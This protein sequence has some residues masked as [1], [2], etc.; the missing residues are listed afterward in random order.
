LEAVRDITEEVQVTMEEVEDL[1]VVQGIT[2][3]A[4]IEVKNSHFH[5]FCFQ[6]F[7]FPLGRGW[8]RRHGYGG[9]F[10]GGPGYGFGGPG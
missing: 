8:R 6:V 5:G 7:T 2:V 9:G 10:G 1:E 4:T 3:V